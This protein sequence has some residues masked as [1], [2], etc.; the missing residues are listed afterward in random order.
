LTRTSGT[1]KRALPQQLGVIAGDLPRAIRGQALEQRDAPLCAGIGRQLR[2]R[3]PLAA[4]QARA[5]AIGERAAVVGRGEREQALRLGEAAV[6]ERELAEPGRCGGIAGSERQHLVEDTRCVRLASEPQQR[7]AQRVEARE[8]ARAARG[9]ARSQPQVRRG[10]LICGIRH[11]PRRARR[12]RRGGEQQHEREQERQR[13]A[14]PRSLRCEEPVRGAQQ[15]L[16]PDLEARLVHVEA[17]VVVIPHQAALAI[18]RA[19]R[20]EAA[21][22]A[23][24]ERREVLAAHG[25]D[26]ST[27][28]FSPTTS[29]AAARAIAAIAGSLIVG[30]LLR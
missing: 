29:T 6:E 1:G 19:H 21:R 23:L 28:F 7:H 14:R 9:V 5:H 15:H 22:H 18:A 25:A 10:F 8:V 3:R 30:R 17:R 27:M 4:A 2:R 13:P 26:P 16:G 24:Q 20:D 12:P 11:E